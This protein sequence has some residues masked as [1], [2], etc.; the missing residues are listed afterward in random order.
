MKRIT[1]TAA[2]DEALRRGFGAE[3]DLTNFAVY[4]VVAANTNPIRKKSG[5]YQNARITPETLLEMANLTNVESRQLILLHNDDSMP[6][7]RLFQGRMRGDAFHGLIALNEKTQPALCSDLDAGVID[8]VSVS[9]LPKQLLCSECGWDYFS[10]AATF[11]NIW[12]CVCGNGHQIGENGVHARL[13]GVDS[14]DELSL[15]GMGAVPGARVIN[16]SASAFS[17]TSPLGLRLAASNKDSARLLMLHASVDQPK[18]TPKMDLTAAIE[19]IAALSA[20][21]ATARAKLEANEATLAASANEITELKAKLEAAL[22]APAPAPQAGPSQAEF[23]AMK[24]SLSDLTRRALVATGN[25]TPTVADGVPEMLAQL[26]TAQE[27]LSAAIPLE[28]RS[29]S[30]KELAA[31]VPAAANRAFVL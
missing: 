19:R 3:A 31:A 28:Q 7:G 17:V 14:F 16:P 20:A 30:S 8:Q 6:V 23:D 2:I 11:E 9:I 26:K 12:G 27:T 10:D 25:Q 1:R 4:E 18:D 24:A 13:V 29:K 5:L 15:C 22:A 21:E